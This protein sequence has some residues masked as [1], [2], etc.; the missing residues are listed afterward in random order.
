MTDISILDTDDIAREIGLARLR[1]MALVKQLAE[2]L[3]KQAEPP[4]AE[5]RHDAP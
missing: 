2:Q 3:A 1:E 4:P 5:R